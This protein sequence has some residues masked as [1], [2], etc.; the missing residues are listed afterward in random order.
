MNLQAIRAIYLFEMARTFRTIWQS[1]VS[2]VI[3]TS[4][5]FIVFGA[6]IGSRIE[7]VEGVSYGAFIVPG[8]IMLTVLQQSV[9]NAAFGIYFPK[10]VGTIYEVLS[11]PVTVIEIVIGYVGAAATKALMIGLIIFATAHLFV[12]LPIV[13][14]VWMIAFLVMTTFFCG[15]RSV[16]KEILIFWTCDRVRTFVRPVHA[17]DMA[18]LAGMVM[19]GAGPNLQQRARG[20]EKVSGLPDPDH[21]DHLPMQIMPSSQLGG[22][23]A[24]SVPD[25]A[26]ISTGPR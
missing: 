26:P 16:C 6:A 23:S 1:I 10:F 7:T 2:P 25:Q 18:P 9:T 15:C 14:P 22:P 19:R 12:D 24:R 20:S 11:A 8:L 17:A 21:V 5:Y 4:L 3:S 13:H